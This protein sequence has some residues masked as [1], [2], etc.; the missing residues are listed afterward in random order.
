MKFAEMKDLVT[1][2]LVLRRMSFDDLYNYYERICSDGNVTRYMK[3]EP[4]QDIGETLEGG[5]ETFKGSG[6]IDGKMQYLNP[7]MVNVITAIVIVVDDVDEVASRYADV[8]DFTGESML[9]WNWKYAFDTNLDAEHQIELSGILSGFVKAY[10]EN[11]THVSK[12]V[13]SQEEQ[14]SDFVMTFGGLFFLGILLSIIFLVSCVLIIYYKQM[15]VFQHFRF[16]HH[17][18]AISITPTLILSFSGLLS[19]GNCSYN[20]I[21]HYLY[22]CYFINTLCYITALII[23]AFSKLFTRQWNRYN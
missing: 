8:T 3:F 21:F 10:M 4:H 9:S 23:S 20:S 5:D 6:R 15:S 16:C 22:S 13:A 11:M 7:D 19:V 18:Y 17:K 1:E 14:R 12:Y 2:R